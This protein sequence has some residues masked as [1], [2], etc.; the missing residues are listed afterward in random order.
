MF[1]SVVR[2]AVAAS[3]SLLKESGRKH[4]ATAFRL[5]VKLNALP[6]RLGGGGDIQRNLKFKVTYF[7]LLLYGGLLL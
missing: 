2:F 6:G 4:F 5:K 1:W 7:V 3:F